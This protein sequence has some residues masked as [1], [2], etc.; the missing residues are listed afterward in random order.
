MVN[1]VKPVSNRVKLLYV[2]SQGGSQ[3]ANF[4]GLVSGKRWHPMWHY[5][6]LGASYV[7]IK[8]DKFTFGQLLGENI[9][10]IYED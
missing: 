2:G 10:C 4:A 3:A 1:G 6:N 8:S 7:Q 5:L 9:F